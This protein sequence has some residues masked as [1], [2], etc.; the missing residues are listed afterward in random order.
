MK[1]QGG[2]KNMNKI[3]LA[4]VLTLMMVTMASA[5]LGTFKVNSCVEIRTIL[6]TTSV[7]LSS[8]T[9]PNGTSSYLNEA[10][11]KS[12]LSTFNYTYCNTSDSGEYVYDYCDL[13]GNC[14]VNSFNINQN[15]SVLTHG[16]A[17]MYISFILLA[18]VVLFASIFGAIN[19]PWK[20]QRNDEGEIISINYLKYL[21]LFLIVMSYVF[22]MFL[23]G[24]SQSIFNNYM[25]ETGVGSFFR[26]MYTLMLSG[27]YPGIVMGFIFSF[28]V[29]IEDKKLNRMLER[30]YW[31]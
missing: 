17:T 25:P 1:T 31:R 6:N 13:E 16:K 7:N 27:L 20:N 8:V 18:I 24:L 21:K 19:I 22:L 9:Y 29:F 10:M 11:T 26:V 30:G 14:Y 5:N 28:L 4:I 2:Y 12:G 3:L 23:F 15:G